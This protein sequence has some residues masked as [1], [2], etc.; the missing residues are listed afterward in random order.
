MVGLKISF[1]FDD[2]LHIKDKRFKGLLG[3]RPGLR[4]GPPC[5]LSHLITKTQNLPLAFKWLTELSASLV[6]QHPPFLLDLSSAPS[7]GRV[8]LYPGDIIAF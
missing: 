2:V 4:P 6:L 1:V 7:D 3:P 5:G 8:V